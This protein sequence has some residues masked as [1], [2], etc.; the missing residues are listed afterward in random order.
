MLNI[1]WPILII[2]SFV[3]SIIS[4]NL[5][6]TSNEIFNSASEAVKLTITL[7]GTV[8]LWNG[9]IEILKNTSLINK[10]TKLLKPIIIKLFPNVKNNKKAEEEISM[11]IVANLLGLGN[12]S[13]P[14]GLKAMNTLQSENPKKDTLSDSMA[15]LIVLNT[16]SLQIIPTNVIAIRN[17]LNST[18]PCGIIIH[19]WI[20]TI[21]AA[22]VGIT[23]TKIILKRF[24]K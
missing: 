1:L 17:A 5:T 18:N 3:F 13:T 11:N 21:I 2:I 24:K 23:T 7:I 22:I 15:M 12:A 16:A 20:S 10:I 9:L 19:V 6:K 8:S 14:L 4:G